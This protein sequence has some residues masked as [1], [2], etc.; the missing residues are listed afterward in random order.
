MLSQVGSEGEWISPWCLSRKQEDVSSDAGVTWEG[1]DSCHQ[2]G[3]L[4]VIRGL[5]FASVLGTLLRICRP[6]WN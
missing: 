6:V 2:A 1:D 5:G 4:G 3:R